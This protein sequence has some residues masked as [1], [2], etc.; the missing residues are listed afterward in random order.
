[1]P[2]QR[3]PP[4]VPKTRLSSTSSVSE[5]VDATGA[6]PSQEVCSASAANVAGETSGTAQGGKQLSSIISDNVKGQGDEREGVSEPPWIKVGKGGKRPSSRKKVSS[7]VLVPTSGSSETAPKSVDINDGRSRT[8]PT[9]TLAL[10]QPGQDHRD[11][12]EQTPKEPSSPLTPV[13]LVSREIQKFDRYT[14]ADPEPKPTTAATEPDPAVCPG[15]P[16]KACNDTVGDDEDG[17]QCDKCKVWFHAGCQG[18]PKLALKA[19]DKHH[20]L[21]LWLC[22]MCKVWLTAKVDPPCQQLADKRLQTLE[23]KITS[24]IPPP[25]Q[26]LEDKI[27]KLHHDID[28]RMKT[29]EQAIAQ[30]GTVISGQA[31]LI[32]KGVKEQANMK[33]TYADIVRDSC[34]SMVDSVTKKVEAVQGDKMSNKEAVTISGVFDDFMD[35]EKRK[36][37]VVAHNLP[38]QPG[39]TFAERCEADSALF[40]CMIREEFSVNVRVVKSFRPGKIM[41]GKPRLLILTLEH[42]RVKHDILKMAPRLRGSTKWGMVYLNPDLTWKE[43]QVNN[44]LRAEL[45]SRRAAGETDLVILRGKLV[46]RK[47]SSDP[48]GEAG[49]RPPVTQS[50][51]RVPASTGTAPAPSANCSLPR[52]VPAPAA[53]AG[54]NQGNQTTASGMTGAIPRGTQSAS[55]H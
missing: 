39:N 47:R 35:K 43:R 55:L 49:V 20:P 3:S 31:R 2:C 21:L 30:Q 29:L 12:G 18:V 15:G 42:E 17:I 22:H 24:L 16:T 14:S 11:K 10:D 41:P 25:T 32:E 19:V 37:N 23:E 7:D 38:E 40:T 44:Q 51:G 8:L 5:L 9:L 6:P 28:S 48:P 26:A 4:R 53:G 27:N 45:H 52:S 34:V 46:S 36:C 1:M 33:S 54:N 50:V 13:G